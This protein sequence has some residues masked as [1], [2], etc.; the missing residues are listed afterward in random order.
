MIQYDFVGERSL[1]VRITNTVGQVVW[2]RD[3]ATTRQG[4]LEVDLANFPSGVYMVQFRSADRQYTTRLMI[5]K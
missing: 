1:D 5:S 2:Q 3:L 4:Q